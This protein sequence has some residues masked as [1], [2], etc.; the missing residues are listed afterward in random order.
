M[1]LILFLISDICICFNFVLQRFNNLF[2]PFRY[3]TYK[4]LISLKNKLLNKNNVFILT[5]FS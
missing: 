2:I 3:G 5:K 1:V 4:S